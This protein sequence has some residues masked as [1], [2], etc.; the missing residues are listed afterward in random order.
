MNFNIL[1]FISLILLMSCSSV[2]TKKEKQRHITK[3]SKNKLSE[4]IKQVQHYKLLASLATNKS[5]HRQYNSASP[6][7][8]CTEKYKETVT[9]MQEHNST[10]GIIIEDDK[11]NIS[12]AS[13]IINGIKE[14]LPKINSDAKFILK[15]VAL[16]KREVNQTF[17]DMVLNK[18]VGIIIT[19]GKQEFITH[20]QK[21]QKGLKLP[22]LFISNKIKNAKESFKIFPNRKNYHLK[23]VKS[24]KERNINKVAILTSIEHKNSSF[25]KLMKAYLKNHNI[26]IV[27]DVEYSKNN[28]D[29]YDMAC[30]KIFNINRQARKEEFLTIQAQEQQKAQESGFKL[31]SKL[32]F[33]PAKTNYQAIII[34]DDF[35][36]VHYFT[37]LF[38]YYQAKNLTLIGN[39]Q[40]RSEELLRPNESFLEG[41]IFIDFMGDYNDLPI[42][43]SSNESDQQISSKVTTDYK[44]MGYYSGLISQLAINKSKKSKQNVL[45]KL[46]RIK[47]KD[48]FLGRRKVFDKNQFNWP[49]FT[50]NVSNNQFLIEK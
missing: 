44:L 7:I 14:S 48:K 26:E 20:I 6:L 32:V 24:L 38:K 40:W 36:T 29:T 43:V 45:R 9:R 50:I 49:S 23:L 46:N 28:F 39:Y 13:A 2:T 17:S 25:M 18:K 27:Y 21:W 22:T 16:K 4:C 3:I 33:L 10:I 35:K 42:N 37:K 30:R 8:L 41:S 15:K 11:E 12:R 1:Y 19:W 47:I 34:P 5:A 31:N